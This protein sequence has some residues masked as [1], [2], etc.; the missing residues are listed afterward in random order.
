MNLD[1]VTEEG[2][3][4]AKQI[5]VTDVVVSRPESLAV[6]G[7]YYDYERIVQLRTRIEASGLRLAA[8]Q[9]VPPEWMHRIRHGLP[10]FDEQV[11]NYCRT[12]EN[13]GRAGVPILGYSFHEQIW[14]S[15]WHTRGR[16]GARFSS[17]DHSLMEGATAVEPEGSGREALWERFERF[18][19]RVIPLAES[20]G[21]RMALHPDDP[22]VSP[23]GG[24][25]YLFT[26]VSAFQRALDM[27]PSPSNGLLFCQGCFAEM[28]GDGV[29]DAIRQFGRQDKVCY[30][31]FRNVVGTLPKFREAFIDNGD[32]DM[33]A[34]LKTWSD[35]GFDGVL[36]PDHYPRVVG[37]SAEA[38]AAR[39][40]AIGY[41][42]GLMTAVERWKV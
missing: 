12:V 1:R 35:V 41:I 19:R 36:I 8:I 33:L 21:L 5:G 28:L 18:I 37:D 14:R 10:G 42:K 39:G 4:F 11:L 13:V 27:V 2:L 23:I 29:F 24:R 20:V 38:N 25:E 34:A 30:V 17:Y 9:G 15:S 40:H 22:P 32:I 31:H 6:A 16:G 7:A 3:Q 26:E